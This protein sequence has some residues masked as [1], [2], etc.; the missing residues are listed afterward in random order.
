MDDHFDAFHRPDI[1]PLDTYDPK[2]PS[3]LFTIPRELRDMICDDVILSGNLK[4]LQTSKQLHHECIGFL[5]K[6]RTCHLNI[7]I[8]NY[9]PKLSLQKP[10]ATLIQNVNIEIFLK[11]DTYVRDWQHNIEPISTF[12]GSTVLRQRCR[13]VLLFAYCDPL[14][15]ISAPVLGWYLDYLR[16]LTEFSRVTLEVLFQGPMTAR[17]QRIWPDWQLA[18]FSCARNRMRDKL[19][20]SIWNYTNDHSC[21]YLEFYPREYLENNPGSSS[22][23]ESLLSD[24]LERH[25]MN[26]AV[27]EYLGSLARNIIRER[28]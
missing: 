7:D 1:L 17:E 27:R 22:P 26:N 6:R 15:D 24:R 19:G 23:V 10:I 5:Y 3:Y 13:V 21:G 28:V 11:S 2:K 20:P 12:S 14:A 8:T 18:I 4:I 9:V 25:E 16:T